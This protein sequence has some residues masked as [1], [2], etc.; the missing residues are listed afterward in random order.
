MLIEIHMI[1]NHS[2]S[3]LNRDDLGAPKTCTFGGV[4]RARISSQCIKRSIR[5]PG[6]QE[7]IHNK[8]S[9]M[10]A[11]AMADH[12]GTKTK[13]FPWLVKQELPKSDIPQDEY[14]RI[15][16]K[17]QRI[18]IS[19]ERETKKKSGIKTDPRPK[20]AQLIHLGP[21]HA[22]F[23]VNKLSEL[24]KHSKQEYDYFLNPEVGFKEMIGD[25]LSESDLPEKDQNKI[26]QSSWIIAK[27]RMNELERDDDDQ[28]TVLYEAIH[29]PDSEDAT[30][31]VEILTGLLTNDEQRFKQLT[32]KVTDE[33]K[34]QLKGVFS[35][36]A[37][38]ID[39][40]LSSLNSASHYSAVDIA[41][42]GR[43]TTSKAFEDVEAAMQVAHAISTHAVVN[44]VDYFSA[45][46][47]LG[48]AGGG[49]GHVDEAMFNSACFYKYFSL[50]WDQFVHN[51][52]PEP[53]KPRDKKDDSPEVKK[54]EDDH[55]KW[56]NE[57]KP[58]AERLAACAL[59]HFIRAAALI[60][61][62]GKQ[63]SFASHCD[64]CGILIE[65][66]ETKIPTSYANA[67]A[68]PVERIGK[69][70]D[71]GPDEKSIE[72]R[73]VACLADHVQS[74]CNAYGIESKRLWYSPKLWK[75]PL[76][77]WVRTKDG[78]KDKALLVPSQRFD[79][80][81]GSNDEAQGLVEAV[82]KILG[83]DWSRIKEEGKSSRT[84]S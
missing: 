68:E 76:Q 18:A 36:K 81:G 21:G 32:A 72:G 38:K 44:E 70:E 13:L 22:S 48:L 62:T 19:K 27:C 47:D 4:P 14:A 54:W 71:D 77:Y 73:S 78:K 16:L 61:P 63:N 20:T 55:D 82:V 60:S 12:I 65:I 46:D 3:N 64:A 17:A 66:K 9:G 58:Q 52:G 67:F 80:L 35:G 84:E 43:M 69:P 49:A 25:I 75:F 56:V 24:R 42:F 53:E 37:I 45:V 30:K 1:Q 29:E 34:K 26:V 40:F 33:E 31:I 23:F 28:V 15:V 79:I 10:F 2:P 51:L 74:L 59:G 8:N 57:V 41:L 11:D 83:F 6:N 5:N 7:E 39:D 50:D